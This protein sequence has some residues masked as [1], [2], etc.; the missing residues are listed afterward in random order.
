MHVETEEFSL[1]N[2]SKN[3]ES[4]IATI[5]IDEVEVLKTPKSFIKTVNQEVESAINVIEDIDLVVLREKFEAEENLENFEFPNN[6]TL[7]QSLNNKENKDARKNIT[8]LKTHFQ[9]L[10]NLAETNVQMIANQ[11]GS[12]IYQSIL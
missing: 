9:N 12:R 5:S 6:A 7:K 10:L 4:E 8:D 1:A 2:I 11:D 3:I